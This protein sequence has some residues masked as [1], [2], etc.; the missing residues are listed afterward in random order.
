M[1]LYWYKLLYFQKIIQI[2]NEED[3][4]LYSHSQEDEC[5]KTAT[6]REKLS[7]LAML[8]IK[9]LLYRTTMSHY[10]FHKN[11]FVCLFLIVL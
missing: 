10:K 11:A 7:C 8:N 6:T 5:S 2:N 4:F 3:T 9:N 1:L